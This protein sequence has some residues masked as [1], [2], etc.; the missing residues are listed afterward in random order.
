MSEYTSYFLYQRYEKRGDQPWLPSYPNTLSIDGG[1]TMP[2][3]V[4]QEDDPACGYVPPV[5]PIY[6]WIDLD[7]TQD[8][9]CADC[10]S[11]IKISGLRSSGQTF[12]MQCNG[13]PTLRRN[14]IAGFTSLEYVRIGS[15]VTEIGDGSLSGQTSLQGVTISPSVTSIGVAA[16]S[17]DVAMMECTLPQSIISI[18]NNAFNHCVSLQNVMLW[19]SITSI[20][21]S[22]F[23]DCDYIISLHIPTGITSIPKY[24]FY[25][26]GA[27]SELNIPNNVTSIGDYAF[28]SCISL[29]NLVIGDGTTHI[30]TDTFSN[31]TGLTNITIGT[32][33]TNIGEG[34]F[35]G[36]IN[37]TSITIKA[38]NPPLLERGGLEVQGTA[39][40]N[41]NNCPIYVPAES[42][43][44]YKAMAD[45][46]N[47]K[48][49]IFP[50]T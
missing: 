4:K 26:C 25:H 12:S 30:G 13:N 14:E 32:G 31:C 21:S 36:G 29:F 47:Y 1:G 45:W 48:N 44:H 41:T 9:I 8:W 15:C 43:S 35:N 19:D 7:P 24:C 23:T 6:R 38:V 46:Y 28:S 3:V 17:G 22:A 27:L 49:R 16:F 33:V 2:L 20:G 10:E 39:F 34:A 42:V 37:L 11:D 18:G 40:D 5:E 50:I